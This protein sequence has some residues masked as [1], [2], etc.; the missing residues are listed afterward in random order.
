MSYCIYLRK[1]RA[2][3]E[4]ELR[5]EGETLTRHEKILKDLALKLQYPI[6]TIY[7]E[8]VSGETIS[9]RPV[10]QQLLSEVEKGKWTGVLVMEVERLAR[11]DTIDQ[12]IVAQA[13]KYSNTLIVTPVKTYNPNNEFDEE[14]FE[15]GLFMSRR[16]YKTI[17]RRLQQG[18]LASV[19]EGKYVGNKNPYGY[20]RVKIQGDKGYT[21]KINEEEAKIV[22]LIFEFYT[23][24][25]IQSNGELSRIGGTKISDYLNQRNIP[26]ATGKPWTL[27]TI[28][29]IIR[30]PVYIGKI[31]WG[32]RPQ[33]KR[34]VNGELIVSRPRKSIEDIILVDGLHQPIIEIK[35]WETAQEIMKTHAMHRTPVA[36]TVSNPLAGLIICKK[37]D[38]KMTKR[39]YKNKSPDALICNKKNCDCASSFL[40]LVEKAVL[41]SL[42]LHLVKFK[43]DSK[44][45][46]LTL[47]QST[48]NRDALNNNLEELKKLNKQIDSLHD[49]LEQGIYDNATFIKRHSLL[50]DKIKSI[51]KINIKLERAIQD[52]ENKNKMKSTIIPRIEHVLTTYPNLD[53]AEQK[54][55]LL[56]TVI[57]KVYYE[58]EPGGRWK[59]KP[60]EFLIEL[61]V[62]L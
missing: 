21:L 56:K 28:S 41:D 37:C 31:K 49:L 50:K 43:A 36:Y 9:A 42:K 7:K 11:G 53:D 60:D 14:Y 20:E 12:G 24:G 5:G 32:G 33:E 17:N 52:E 13:F 6:D 58:K 10:M 40:Y 51:Q 35:Q 47:V 2:D 23:K 1:S 30:N 8:I 61:Y 27:Q 25:Q 57:E 15:F 3:E 45:G 48:S 34:V 38:T 29:G 22:K 26:S 4:A 59:V 55:N 39:P 19:K 18:R 46:I 62:K 54:N 16:E 44:N